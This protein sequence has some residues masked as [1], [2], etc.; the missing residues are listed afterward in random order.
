[1]V[2]SL[3]HKTVYHE[4]AYFLCTSSNAYYTL[5]KDLLVQR[6]DIMEDKYK[7]IKTKL[8]EV[9]QKDEKIKAI[10]A[11]GSSTRQATK[12]DEYSDLDLNIA[13]E[14][15]DSWLYGEI[16]E[17]LGNLKISFVEPT[18]GSGK[19]RRVF[20]EDALDVDMIVYTPMQFENVIK[21]G[22]ASWVCNRGYLVLYDTLD[23]SS[24]MAQYVSKEIKCTDLSESEFKNLVHDFY[25]HII[26]ASKKILRGELWSAKMCIDAY[27]KNYLLKMIE[28]YSSCSYQVDVWHDGRFLDRWADDTTKEELKNCFA[29]YDRDDMVRAMSATFNFFRR[30]SQSVA[31][32]RKYT[33]PKEAEEYA[34]SFIDEYF[35]GTN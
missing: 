4:E 34:I 7:A 31:D 33:Y 14:D 27:L 29:H 24:M 30:L 6:G 23:F 10:I 25:F 35:K 17:Q 15:I 1:M 18:L 13:T 9:A 21:E 28:M 11:I 5:I 2:V 22:V 19:E 26:W 12:A 16:P 8:L 3:N 20:Y 32:F